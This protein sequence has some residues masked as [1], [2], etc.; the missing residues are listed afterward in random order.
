MSKQEFGRAV[1]SVPWKRLDVCVF[2]LLILSLMLYQLQNLVPQF[3]LLHVRE[4]LY[5]YLYARVLIFYRLRLT[6]PLMVMLLFLAGAFAVA[7]HTY[8]LAGQTVAM[9][10]FTRFVHLALAAPLAA[11]LLEKDED[12]LMVLYLWMGVV[13]AGIM[14]VVYQMF[15]GEMVW[16]VQKYIAIRGDLVRHM[17]LMGEPN[18]GG[19]SAALLYLL[20]STIIK[21]VAIRYF[22]LFASSFLVIVS[23]SKAAFVGFMLANVAILFTDYFNT[24]KIG[25]AF[26]SR[27]LIVQT[28]AVLG[29]FLLL[30]CHPLLYQYMEVGFNSFIG[31][32]LA[33]PGAIEDFGDRFV[34]SKYGGGFALSELRELLFGQSFT[35]AGSVAVE[36][37]IPNAAGPH[38]MYLEVYLVG[39]LVLLCTLITIQVLVIKM[40]VRPVNTSPKL[41]AVLLSLFVLISLYMTGYP[42]LYE[43]IT[44]TLFWLIVGVTCRSFSDMTA[45]TKLNKKLS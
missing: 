40:L 17:S 27:E 22:L 3:A 28:A 23:I 26:P 45:R 20:S 43:P 11:V 21:K 25:S 13:T 16:L 4:A 24:R 6:L 32:Q 12:I 35:R 33:V 31:K 7:I 10:A 41:Y 42:N 18:V 14:T 1:M 37:K 36:L 29:W 44:G 9:R 34:F 39:G 2:G 5:L 19:I 30:A 15:G 38:N 8:F